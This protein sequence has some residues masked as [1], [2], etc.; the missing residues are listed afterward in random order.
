[1]ISIGILRYVM[2]LLECVVPTVGV[3]YLPAPIK[4]E[5][6]VMRSFARVVLN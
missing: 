4:C 2:Q 3:I 5:R 1:M 6:L